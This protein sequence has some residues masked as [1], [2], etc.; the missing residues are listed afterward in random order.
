MKETFILIALIL[1][2]CSS[3]KKKDYSELDY[4]SKKEFALLMTKILILK[5]DNLK[6]ENVLEVFYRVNPCEKIINKENENETLKKIDLAVCIGNFLRNKVSKKFNF[7]DLHNHTYWYLSV[8]KSLES[9]VVSPE[10]ETYF[11]KYRKM[12][13]MDIKNAFE[14]IN[15]EVF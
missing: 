9:Q 3:N 6:D 5:A 4:I 7:V 13:G 1:T 12:S 10:S 14:K 11:G 8:A 2:G 15:Q